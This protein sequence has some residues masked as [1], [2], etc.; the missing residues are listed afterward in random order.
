VGQ[1]DLVIDQEDAVQ[2]EQAL[3]RFIEDTGTRVAFVMGRDG[4][5]LAKQGA[6]KGLDVDSMCALAVGA[7]ASS[8]AL[9]H[10]AGEEIF[11]S[12]YHQGVCSNVYLSLISDS[13]LL[14]VLFDYNASPPLVRLQARVAAEAVAIVLERAYT[15][16]REQSTPL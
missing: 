10:M 6:L 12:I 9:A 15:R 11:N 5:L 7:F 3:L 16:T 1:Y 13:H 2:I 14:L 4:T 8:E